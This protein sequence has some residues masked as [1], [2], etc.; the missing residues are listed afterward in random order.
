MQRDDHVTGMHSSLDRVAKTTRNSLTLSFR[1][2]EAAYTPTQGVFPCDYTEGVTASRPETLLVIAFLRMKRCGQPSL[3]QRKAVAWWSGALELS[4][5]LSDC[6]DASRKHEG[7]HKSKRL[8][9]NCN[10]IV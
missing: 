10:C 6:N 1:V 8:G 2:T 9:D 5:V 7:R 4:V 3:L